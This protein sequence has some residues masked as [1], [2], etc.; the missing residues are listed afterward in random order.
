MYWKRAWRV[1]AIALGVVLAVSLFG[2][3][4][5]VVSDPSASEVQSLFNSTARDMLR[6]GYGS[7]VTRRDASTAAAREPI[8]LYTMSVS[9]LGFGSTLEF[10][11]QNDW[12]VPVTAGTKDLP[13][14]GIHY[15]DDTFTVSGI[16]ATAVATAM[17]LIKASHPGARYPRLV[18]TQPGTALI[19][20]DGSEPVGVTLGGGRPQLPAMTVFAGQDLVRRVDGPGQTEWAVLWLSLLCVVVG[21]AVWLALA[22][23][24]A[25]FIRRRSHGASADSGRRGKGWRPSLKTTRGSAL[26][27]LYISAALIPLGVGTVA[28]WLV[29]SG[30]FVGVSAALAL[31]ADV[32]TVA[33]F[34][35]YVRTVVL[36]ASGERSPGGVL[37]IAF[38][39][40]IA[41]EAATLIAFFSMF[42][43]QALGS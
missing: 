31:V 18:A 4:A 8:R 14:F 1:A 20:Y 36:L 42:L 2:C 37:W 29:S 35:V 16:E 15:A 43:F 33:L 22:L 38:S 6:Q 10:Q 26:S 21:F 11:P 12:M 28:V 39:V 9:G 25:F 17:E 23:T 32:L 41:G 34:A 7:W 5:A 30:E 24:A 3:G 19:M 13:A 27:A 40:T